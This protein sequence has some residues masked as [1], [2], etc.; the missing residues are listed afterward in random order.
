MIAA[1]GSRRI[2]IAVKK[3]LVDFFGRLRQEAD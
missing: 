3:A 2:D 1:V